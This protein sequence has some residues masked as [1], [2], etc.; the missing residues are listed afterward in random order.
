LLRNGS[1]LSGEADEPALGPLRRAGRTSV[2][3]GCRNQSCGTCRVLLDGKLVRTCDL[4]LSA[5][6]SGA[7]LETLEDLVHVE[8]AQKAVQRFRS[9]RPTRCEL[10]VGSV[11]VMAAYLED[12]AASDCGQIL[13]GAHCQC[14]GRGSL[15]RALTG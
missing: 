10:C 13:D 8:A 6:Q 15:R 2:L 9:E 7:H 3:R 14:T 1:V 12:K 11:G 5:I 4:P